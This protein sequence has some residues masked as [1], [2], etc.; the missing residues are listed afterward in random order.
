MNAADDERGGV[1]IGAGEEH[2]HALPDDLI[3]QRGEAGKA[4]RDEG[5]ELER[6]GVHRLFTGPFPSII[7]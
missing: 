7:P 5:R 1:D 3:Q 2:E 6:S 4:E